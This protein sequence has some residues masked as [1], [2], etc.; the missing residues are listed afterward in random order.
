[1]S[2]HQT[3]KTCKKSKRKSL[4]KDNKVKSI[5]LDNNRS[6]GFSKFFKPS[7]P[8]EMS[9]TTDVVTDDKVIQEY[10]N[11]IEQGELNNQENNGEKE[12]R[13]Y[14]MVDGAAK[15]RVL[16][17]IVKRSQH[18]QDNLF[19]KVTDYSKKYFKAT[20]T[21]FLGRVFLSNPYKSPLHFNMFN[22]KKDNSILMLLYIQR[23]LE[24]LSGIL[25]N[26]DQKDKDVKLMNSYV[27]NL[28]GN[29][30]A[31]AMKQLKHAITDDITLVNWKPADENLNTFKNMADQLDDADW[32]TLKNKDTIP[33]DQLR[34]QTRKRLITL[35]LIFQLA[36][37]MSELYKVADTYIG[38]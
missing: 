30:G 38:S 18:Y 3:E 5:E 6:M 28:I 29:Q 36:Q 19:K 34:D 11:D 1:M 17:T 31:L 7:K 4:K 37:L 2:E 26:M 20:N 8:L 23:V 21:T 12:V 22:I 32:P 25:E 16:R 9:F 35:T 24:Q 15:D 27:G 33:V 14:D 10:T 13:G